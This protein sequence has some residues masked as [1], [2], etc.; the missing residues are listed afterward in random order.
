MKNLLI[1]G[2]GG[3]GNVIKEIAEDIGY[4]RIGFIDDINPN[5]LGKIKDVEKFKNY[6][7]AFVSIGNNTIR[8]K[9]LSLLKEVGYHIP[10]LIHP[11]AYV[12]KSAVI[13]EGTVIEPK[14]IVNTHT[15]VGKGSIV[16]VGAIIDH[17]VSLGKCVHINAGAIVKAGGKVEDFEKLDA[18]KVRENY[19]QAKVVA[20]SND[21]F[22]KE[23]KEK[24]GMDISFF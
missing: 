6:Q 14:A 15:K 11:T 1:I 12:S 2:A 16:S 5:A 21:D 20:N 10:I 19:K 23:E 18:G 7:E 24:T 22:I 17:D 4:E 3:H 9:L 13:E 8:N